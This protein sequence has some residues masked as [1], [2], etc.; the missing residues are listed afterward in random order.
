MSGSELAPFVAA[1]IRD[2]VVAEMSQEIERLRADLEK[3]KLAAVRSAA[4]SNVITIT[5]KGGTPIYARGSLNDSVDRF[6]NTS[7]SRL[8]NSDSDDSLEMC[9]VREIENAEIRKGGEFLFVLQD[10]GVRY[11]TLGGAD[12]E[13]YGRFLYSFK[14]EDRDHQ[15]VL[16]QVGVT[17][18][19]PIPEALATN[20]SEQSPQLCQNEDI[21]EV[22]FFTTLV[23]VL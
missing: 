9:P 16:V 3:V 4:F 6:G 20:G 7:V 10:Y 21:A 23:S 14:C 2:K 1:T 15:L 13:R 22:K 19:G 17:N 8:T 11:C 5:G 18:Y 12:G